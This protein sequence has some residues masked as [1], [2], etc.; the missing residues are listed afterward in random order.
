[1]WDELIIV[2]RKLQAPEKSVFLE[3]TQKAIL[4]ALSQKGCFDSIVFQGGTALRL[5]HGNIRFSEDIDLV[6]KEEKKD[7]TLEDHLSTIKR[8]TE[9]SFPFLENVSI[10]VQKQTPEIQR[11][12][13]KTQSDISEQRLRVHIELA[14]IPSYQNRPRILHYPPLH[15]VLR[16]ED[17]EEIL[18]D[19]VTALA[20]RPYLKGRDL[21]DIYYL[22]IE[23]DISIPWGLVYRKV[24]DYESTKSEYIEKMEKTVLEI[25]LQ[26]EKILKNELERFL[27]PRIFKEYHLMLA[28]ILKT[29]VRLVCVYKNSEGNENESQ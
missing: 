11:Y 4:T 16:V 3:E 18:A 23:R 1:M 17:P 6:L 13:L 26:G 21:W 8:F 28:D 15:P 24:L 19:K 29:V 10:K 7:Y 14:R 5:F 12:V 9:N 22:S 25:K 27:P 2:S 20:L